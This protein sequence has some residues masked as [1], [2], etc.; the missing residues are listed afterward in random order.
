METDRLEF[1]RIKPSESIVSVS[2]TETRSQLGSL[3]IKNA[4]LETRKLEERI[5]IEK[6][7]EIR[8]S[9]SK[10]E[11]KE[12]KPN[13]I[14]YK[15]YIFIALFLILCVGSVILFVILK[16]NE[17]EDILNVD[18]IDEEQPFLSTNIEQIE[19][20]CN[21]FIKSDFANDEVG[22]EEQFLVCT[23]DLN[24][25]LCVFA[26]GP[27]TLPCGSSEPCVCGFGEFIDLRAV[28]GNTNNI[29]FLPGDEQ[30]NQTCNSK[31]I[32]NIDVN[33]ITFLNP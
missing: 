4:Q 14:P 1:T 2:T 5:Q 8:F 24:F 20:I 22:F 33:L 3:W 10:S 7:R 19:A 27:F 13:E 18:K 9:L 28:S 32:D 21:N 6:N 23:D 25:V 29:C 31:L 30:Q 11:P 12:R 15:T 17:N 26:F 16:Q